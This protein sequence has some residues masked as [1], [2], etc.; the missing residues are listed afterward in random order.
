[1]TA[2]FF[3]ISV[4]NNKAFDW[5]I[6]Q[7]FNVVFRSSSLLISFLIGAYAFNNKYVLAGDHARD[8]KP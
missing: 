7:P 6:S 1:M 8:G 4:A 5:G 3:L 2:L